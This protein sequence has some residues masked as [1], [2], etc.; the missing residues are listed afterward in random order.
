MS[1][2]LGNARLRS[3]MLNTKPLYLRI[4]C[5]HIMLHHMWMLALL[6]KKGHANN[7]QGLPKKYHILRGSGTTSLQIPDQWA[8]GI[9]KPL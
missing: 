8:T 1:V 4:Q 3:L 7:L 6:M 5:R 9:V 2:F